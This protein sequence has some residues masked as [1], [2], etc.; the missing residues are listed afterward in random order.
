MIVIADSDLIEVIDNKDIK[1]NNI[2]LEAKTGQV[3]I[4]LSIF[5][6]TC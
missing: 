4:S 2:F 6:N 1:L 5:H 3:M